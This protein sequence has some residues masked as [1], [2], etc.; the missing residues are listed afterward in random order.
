VSV[1][2][3]ARFGRADA[4]GGTSFVGF[5]LAGAQGYLGP[6]SSISVSA[7]PATGDAAQ[8]GTAWPRPQRVRK[9]L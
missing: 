7:M 5:T 1:V 9:T 2:G 4:L 8:W 6:P 3:I